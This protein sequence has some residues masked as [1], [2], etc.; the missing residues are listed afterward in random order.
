MVGKKATHHIPN[1]FACVELIKL[2]SNQSELESFDP[3]SVH[4]RHL[5]SQFDKTITL[6]PERNSKDINTRYPSNSYR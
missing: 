3:I 4:G 6:T 5:E 1:S 2:I